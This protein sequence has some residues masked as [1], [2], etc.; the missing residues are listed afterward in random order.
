MTSSTRDTCYHRVLYLFCPT[1]VFLTDGTDRLRNYP[2][3]S[4]LL[5]IVFSKSFFFCVQEVLCEGYSSLA[6]SRRSLRKF[7]SLIRNIWTIF[8][9]ILNTNCVYISGRS[10]SRC[11]YHQRSASHHNPRKKLKLHAAPNL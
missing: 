4:G 10:A 2:I 7:T 3:S 1:I 11:P 9:S 5:L 6:S 8:T